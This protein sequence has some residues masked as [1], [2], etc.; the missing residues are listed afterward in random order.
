MGCAPF[1]WRLGGPRVPQAKARGSPLPLRPRTGFKAKQ[2]API[3]SKAPWSEL[4]P[5]IYSQRD[6]LEIWGRLE[7]DGALEEEP[8][9]P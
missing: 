4:G 8:I 9:G 1:P 2:N 7:L 5:Q 3:P 6:I